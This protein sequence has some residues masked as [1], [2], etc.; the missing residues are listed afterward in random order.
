[1]LVEQLFLE[2]NFHSFFIYDE[3]GEQSSPLLFYIK[4]TK[5]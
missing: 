1:M 4:K 3:G 5:I 2:L